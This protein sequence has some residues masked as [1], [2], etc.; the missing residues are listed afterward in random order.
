M[1]IPEAVF[2]DCELDFLIESAVDDGSEDE[3]LE[4]DRDDIELPSSTVLVSSSS[5]IMMIPEAVFQDFQLD[6]LI[7][8]TV[9]DG[10]ED[11]VLEFDLDDIELPSSTTVVT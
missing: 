5:D 1:M 10:S 8:S 7:E 6:F 2:Q 11:E 9:N 4:C 3:V